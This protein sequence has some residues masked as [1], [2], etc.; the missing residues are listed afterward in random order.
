M[1][2]PRRAIFIVDDDP[3]ARAITQEQIASLGHDVI[4]CEGGAE[5]LA[6]LTSTPDIVLLD[7]EMPGMD[8]LAVCSALRAAG[9]LETEVIFL[10]GH[11]D[12]ETR[13]AAYDAGGSGF[14]AKPVAAADLLQK[15]A[16][17]ERVLA[18][19][20]GLAGNPPAARKGAGQVG[21]LQGVLQRLA[22]CQDLESV[23]DVVLAEVAGLDMEGVAQARLPGNTLLRSTRGK[24][25][26]LEESLVA[27]MATMGRMTLHGSRLS[28]AEDHVLLLVHGLP[29]D[30]PSICH[31]L[32]EHFAKLVKGAEARISALIHSDGRS[33]G[34]MPL[35]GD[36]DLRLALALEAANAGLW[37]WNIPSGNVYLSASYYRMLGYQP[38]EFAATFVGWFAQVHEDDTP[39]LIGQIADLYDAESYVDPEQDRLEIEFRMRTKER[40]WRWMHSRGTVIERDAEGFPM[41]IIGINLDITETRERND[42]LR[43]AIEQQA[44]LNDEV[45]DA[46]KQLLQSEKMA[47]IGQLA[48]GVAHELN[49]PI[50]FVHSNLGALEKYVTDIFSIA[51]A[52]EELDA[53]PATLGPVL[54]KVRQ[55]K[56]ACDYDYLKEDVKQLMSESKD[57]LMRV[58]KIVQD[59]KDFSRVDSADWGWADLHRGIDS[60]LNI[61]ANELKYHCTVVKEYGEL[62][63]VHCLLSQL[64]QV[65]MNLLVNAAHAIEG[66]GEGKG[67]I[68]IRSGCKDKEVWVS[69]SDTG[70]GIAPE[71]LNRIFDP[72][73]TT[74]P[75]GKGTG[76]G[77]SLA[78]GIVKKHQGR[79]D[80]ASELGRGT[81]FT[82]T[83]PIEP[84]VE[85]VETGGD[86]G[87]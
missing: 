10:S 2:N 50:G 34:T 87:A 22:A 11:D 56:Q 29:I 46:H 25:S 70:K 14:I 43:R 77:L 31:R 38:D 53:D 30:F 5:F 37:D 51:A 82:L 33:A 9:H 71:N 68:T 47:S 73:F 26:D 49:N 65:F 86:A 27:R 17:S 3:I 20:A 79:L 28:I 58:R 24:V 72:F 59:L 12:L 7:I 83:L 4:E 67:T 42:K 19:G 66:K 8:G 64:N 15:L 84:A 41:R 74:K 18:G 75:V 57:G 69:V 48:A 32:R 21:M 1:G 63:E 13:L 40:A 61:V 39:H 45:E 35:E 44:R 36:S 78:Y 55:L 54:E 85:A 52:Y 23:V 62:P 16:I 76:L 60:T 6:A 80:V 81:T